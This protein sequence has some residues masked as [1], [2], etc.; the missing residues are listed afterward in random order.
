MTDEPNDT[1]TCANRPQFGSPTGGKGVVGWS[2]KLHGP[3][4]YRAEPE[5]SDFPGLDVAA[6]HKSMA[7]VTEEVHGPNSACKLPGCELPQR[8]VKGIAGI[9]GYC[10]TRCMC[11]HQRDQQTAA[12]LRVTAREVAEGDAGMS[13]TEWLDSEA[14]AIE[15]GERE[16]KPSDASGLHRL[17]WGDDDG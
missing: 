8:T 17:M 12:W 5:P 3:M 16:E 13:A 11:Y 7:R 4:Q 15:R 1:C 9:A 10:S 2:C 14:D 6:S